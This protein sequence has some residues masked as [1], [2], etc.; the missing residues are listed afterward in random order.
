MSENWSLIKE[1][2]E[3]ALNRLSSERPVFVHAACNG[4][5]DL[6]AAVNKLLLADE[7]AGSF[8]EGTTVTD[9]GSVYVRPI[10]AF[11]PGDIV[12]SRFEILRFL[13][14]GG[15]GEVYEARDLE[16]GEHLALKTIR[17]DIVGD[18][19]A[20]ARFKREIQLTRRVTHPN[21]CRMFD[22]GHHSIRVSG[23]KSEIAILTMEL[24]D[25]ETLSHRL[26]RCG[27]FPT[28][29]ALPL[30]RDITAALAAAHDVGV[31]H[32]DLKPSNVM[33]VTRPI[34]LTTEQERA[35]RAVVMDFGLARTVSTNFRM[36]STLDSVTDAG[37][38]V[39][40]LA[41][42]APEQLEAGEITVA[43]DVYALGLVM[44]EMVTGVRPFLEDSPMSA[45][46]KRLSTQPTPPRMLAPQLDMVW[47]SVIL[48]C[49]EHKPSERFASV[50]DIVKVLDGSLPHSAARK[51]R[52]R[53]I[54]AL[55]VLPFLRDKAHPETEYLADGIT[56]SLINLL[57]QL[58]KL[59]VMARATIF[60][61]KDA[62]T[63]S[64][65]IGRELGVDAIVMGRIEQR[66]QHLAVAAELID[67]SDGSLIWGR[68]YTHM[69]ATAREVEQ[70]LAMDISLEMRPRLQQKQRQQL[71]KQ[72]TVS[73]EAYDLYLRGRFYWNQRTDS[74]LRK[75]IQYFQG[76]IEKDNRYALAYAGL[77][78]CFQLLG[79]YRILAPEAAFSQAKNAAMSALTIDKRLPE[80][81]T[82]LALAILY[83]DWNWPNAE[84]EFRLAIR[85]G[86]NYPTAHQWYTHYL[87]A[88]GRRSEALASIE[89]AHRLDPLSLAIN[90]HRGW[91]FY[92]LRRFEEAVDQLSK[93][94]ELD[95]RYTLA[96]FVS[97]QCYAQLGR[98][99]EAVSELQL[100]A[101]L[102]GRLPSVLS[103]L[104]H[105]CG[106]MGD[107]RG[108]ETLLKE[109][110]TA[111]R[112]RYVSAYDIA[113][114]HLGL[115]E[116]DV[117]V[118]LLERAFSERVS[119]MI[120]LKA[121]PVFDRL[122]SDQRFRQLAQRVGLP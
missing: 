42:M 53:T 118:D 63:E 119:W 52:S 73:T 113:L 87:M 54:D 31:V 10:R 32:R 69:L 39:G 78:D 9:S 21:V 114:V 95:P 93:T 50:G 43:T 90:T 105:T 38:L 67:V 17:S 92:F 49:L 40:T 55:A 61:Y 30:V 59:R 12:S 96:H 99:P 91:A 24:L 57:S 18:R 117:A 27:A 33:I 16:L 5:S 46:I 94:I 6:E 15:M 101:S 109:L 98:F 41:Y 121:E 79:G 108:A 51:K 62:L 80:A 86:P 88:M 110:R 68:R 19:S 89:L 2:F 106:L 60:R 107:R 23:K 48:R 81:H 29:K 111:A 102:S 76:A 104:A 14:E 103:A 11:S 82:S 7:H 1:V 35:E 20:I 36:L 8:L 72:N 44:Y 26:A 22:L 75:G 100:A 28:N 45:A 66:D 4:D 122:R 71:F 77:S 97:G 112:E 74:G 56:E 115:G 13:G 37:R 64:L 47:E 116:K 70:Q 3:A 25:G 84:K 85:L 58:P 65:A 34:A 120:W 83:F